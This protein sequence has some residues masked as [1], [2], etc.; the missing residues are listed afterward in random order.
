MAKSAAQLLDGP[1][2]VFIEIF[3]LEGLSTEKIR[4][5]NTFTSQHKHGSKVTEIGQFHPMIFFT[6]ETLIYLK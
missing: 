5:H 3:F 2:L 4:K 6:L 1:E